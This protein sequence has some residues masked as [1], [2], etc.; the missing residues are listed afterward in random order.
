LSHCNQE[1]PD[2]RQIHIAELDF[3]DDHA[4]PQAADAKQKHKGVK[5]NPPEGVSGIS[6]ARNHNVFKYF[7]IS[8]AVTSTFLYSGFLLSFMICAP[9]PYIH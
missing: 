2:E 7:E 3:V 4:L 9:R 6:S 1:S 8:P 5:G